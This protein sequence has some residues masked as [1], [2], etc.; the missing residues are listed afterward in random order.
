MP[1][2]NRIIIASAGSGK[3]TTIVDEASGYASGRSALIT[4]TNNNTA[5]LRDKTYEVLGFI[6]L[7]FEVA[8]WYT[9]LLRH[10]VRPYQNHVY[11][12][13]IRRVGF[14]DGR[15]A[16][17]VAKDN[18]DRFY[19]LEPGCIYLDKVSQF[20][21]TVI[22]Q[23]RGLPLAR[24]AA[25]FDRIY[26]DEAQDLAGYDLD[27]VEHLLR[28]GIAV[29]LVGDVRQATYRTNNSPRNS[30]Y[31]GAKIIDMFNSWCRKTDTSLEH[32][33]HSHRCV[34][35]ICDFAD[36]FYPDLPTAVSHNG[37]VTGHDGVFAV[38]W[39]D[40]DHYMATYRPQPLR[41]DR[42]T[43]NVPGCPLNFGEAK[44]KTFDRTLIFP[45]K[46]LEA[47]LA[48]GNVRE[49]GDADVTVARVY[50]GITRARQSVGIVIPDRLV[51][52]C[53][54]IYSPE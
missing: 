23:T 22:D 48:T 44:G 54:P 50:V 25:I 45:H 43:K 11:K 53:L 37:R 16:R 38:R 42:R 7:N 13:P 33:N 9:F 8:T 24:A 39:S 36:Q 1:S 17:Y 46:K 28:T 52:A 34:Q 3:T 26:I 32:Q 6:P 4:Y 18:I 2:H 27:L 10:F 5:E 20:A 40:V 21:C 35:P 12:T 15:S 14:V 41:L 31:S 19:F 51:P 29:T 47:V 49:L 30:Q